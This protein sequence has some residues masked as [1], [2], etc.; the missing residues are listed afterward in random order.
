MPASWVLFVKSRSRKPR[1][2][3]HEPQGMIR[4]G[5]SGSV[6]DDR[7]FLVG[8]RLPIQPKLT[9]TARITCLLLRFDF[10]SLRISPAGFHRRTKFFYPPLSCERHLVLKRGL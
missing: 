10:S 6:S 4:S 7:S 5:N 9:T 8:Q 2:V 1:Q 3:P